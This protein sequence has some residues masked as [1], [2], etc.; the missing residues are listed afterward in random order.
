MKGD[1]DHLTVTAVQWLYACACTA[2]TNR[3]FDFIVLTNAAQARTQR[4]LEGVRTNPLQMLGNGGIGH[5]R[6]EQ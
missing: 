4:G 6:N 3:S 5:G 2:K 1:D